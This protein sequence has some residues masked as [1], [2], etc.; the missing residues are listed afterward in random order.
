MI[1]QAFETTSAAP[2]PPFIR[3]Q[4]VLLESRLLLGYDFESCCF[5]NA[6]VPL[7][8]YKLAVPHCAT[9]KTRKVIVEMIN[10]FYS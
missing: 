5:W 3:N 8:K 2:E 1:L 7:L 6:L 9:V 4:I 10:A